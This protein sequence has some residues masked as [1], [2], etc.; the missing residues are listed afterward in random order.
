M[1]RL[2]MVP[3]ENLCRKHLVAEHHECHVFLGKLKHQHSL[4][5]YI[6]H[7]LFSLEDLYWRHEAL[8]SELVKRG[9]YHATP[10][11]SYRAVMEYGAYLPEHG[12]IDR[13]AAAKELY[14]RC[15]AC[16]ANRLLGQP[17]LTERTE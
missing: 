14:G 6:D 3:P 17:A 2:W 12:Q 9:Y 5:G 1:P 11:P 4:T 7:N 8:T 15:P 10:F 13:E 16:N